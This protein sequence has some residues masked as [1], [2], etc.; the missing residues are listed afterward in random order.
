PGALY[1]VC[2]ATPPYHGPSAPGSD[3]TAPRGMWGQRRA[4]SPTRPAAL[5][6]LRPPLAGTGGTRRTRRPAPTPLG[7]AQKERAAGAALSMHHRGQDQPSRWA[8]PARSSSSSAR[9]L[10]MAFW[11]NSSIG[12]SL[13][14]VYLPFS[15]VTGKPKIT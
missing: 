11:L 14:R 4:R 1:D 5:S 7:P 13:T 6:G 9:V 15:V 12:R 8:T 2:F 3:A 10:S